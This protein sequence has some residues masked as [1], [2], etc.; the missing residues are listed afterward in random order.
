MLSL[1]AGVLLSQERVSDRLNV[2]GQQLRPAG[3]ITRTGTR[4]VDLLLSRD[5]KRLWVKDN[6]G[7]KLFDP[8]T[9]EQKADA[10]SEGGA[11]L[12]GLAET[13]DGKILFSN[14]ASSIHVFAIGPDGKL[15]RERTIAIPAGTPT[16]AVFPCGLAVSGGTVYAALS[17]TNE[18]AA[19]DLASGQVRWRTKVGVSPYGVALGPDGHAYVSCMGG[20]FPGAKSRTAPSAGTETSVDSRGVA[21]GGSVVKVRLSDGALTSQAEVGGQ[22][23]G[24]ILSPGGMVYVACANSDTISVLDAKTLARQMDIPVRLAEGL[25]WGLMPN[26]LALS[27]SRLWVAC[28]GINAVAAIDLGRSPVTRGFLPTGWHP[29]GVAVGGG[30]VFV[31]N[32]KGLGSRT[33]RRPEEQGWNSYDYTGLIQSV[34]AGEDLAT[35]TQTVRT[36]A[37]TAEMLRAMERE[38]KASTPPKAWPAKL[39]DPSHIKHVIYVI[40]ENRT[41]DQYFG[42]MKEGKG[43]ARL[44]LYKDDVVPN[45]RRLAR[46]YV[47]LDNYYC[48]GVLSADGHSWATEGNVTPYLEKAFGG[49]T[50]SYTFGDD[51]LTYSPTG[52]IWDAVLSAGMTF[53]N[54]GEMDYA[55]P[56]QGWS[57][58]RLWNEYQNGAPGV[59]FNQNIGIRRLRNF[60]SRDYPGW[61][62]GIPDVLRMERFLSEF[63]RME[64][65]PNLTI[66]YLPQDHGAGTTP[67]YPTMSSYMADNDLAVGRLVEAVSR[68]RFWPNTAIFINEDD[69]QAGFD[70]VDGHRS[71]CLVVSPYTKQKKTVSAFYNQSG[72]VRSI[73]Y[74]LGLPPLNTSVAAS[75]LMKECF[76]E[77]GDFSPYSAITPERDRTAI[78][79]PLEAIKDPKLR[80]LAAA[81]AKIDFRGPDRLSIREEDTLNRAVW[82]SAK[83][84]APYPKEWA[85]P[86]GRGLKARGLKLDR[87]VVEDD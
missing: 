1:I 41:Y 44:N 6:A 12:H 16:G 32:V 86:H 67:G 62:M 35:G 87:N 7:L 23:S 10:A 29:G 69:P 19:I 40:K 24:I 15:T 54:Y 66:L 59:V 50:R 5:G 56:P 11:S 85:G 26:A 2:V 64:A 77:K 78:N 9:L 71:I 57:V 75:P 42:D 4:P 60:S 48:N 49:F 36:A 8:V 17:R 84:T 43:D 52:H 28:A 39:G 46:E 25:P 38:G 79:P 47:L 82:G 33:R 65:L 55:T 27:G 53:R 73:L 37:R 76:T 14:S 13:A 3:L 45:H 18:L 30:R 68:S 20:A 74:L 34:S 51:P 21:L 70:H 22:A 81:C 83:G 72:V 63:G 80:A 61:N 31:A 58:S